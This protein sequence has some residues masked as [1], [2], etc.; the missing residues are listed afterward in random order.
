[1]L[2]KKVF[3]QNILNEAIF[4]MAM[5]AFIIIT[6]RRVYHSWNTQLKIVCKVKENQSYNKGLGR[7]TLCHKAL[8]VI[9]D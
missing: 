1:M 7:F 5:N 8:M 6:F 3:D 4:I 2:P 9:C